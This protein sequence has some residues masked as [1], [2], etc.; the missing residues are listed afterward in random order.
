MLLKVTV[1][2]ANIQDREGGKFLLQSLGRKLF[3]MKKIWVDCAYRGQFVKWVEQTFGWKVIV[4]Q[5]SKKGWKLL[6]HRWV[7]ERTFGWVCR[8]RRLSKDYEESSL[9]EEG[10]FY[11]AMIRIMLRRITSECVR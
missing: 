7:V 5:R 11:L 6:P 2:P 10:W 3:Y 1:L 9:S 8:N 4:I